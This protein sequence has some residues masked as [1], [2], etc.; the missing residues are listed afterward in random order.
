MI[1]PDDVNS[2]IISLGKEDFRIMNPMFVQLMASGVGIGQFLASA[3]KS[4]AQYGSIITSL[5]GVAMVIVGIYQ[6]AKNLISGGK[7]QTNWVTTICLIMIGGALALV[8]GWGTVGKL[9]NTGN[10][11]VTQMAQGQAD[12]TGSV[13]DPFSAGAAGT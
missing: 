11:T 1:G 9:V 5:I 6:V 10:T 12:T 13:T 2:W 4:L 7:G 3:Q 8:G